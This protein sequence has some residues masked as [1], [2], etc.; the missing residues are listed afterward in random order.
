M[1]Y[2]DKKK[3]I[4]TMNIDYS[5]RK[6]IMSRST[7]LGYCICDPRKPCPCEELKNFNVCECAGEKM[8]QIELGKTRIRLTEHVKSAGCASKISKKTLHEILSG[9]PQ[10][11]DAR[12]LVGSSAGDDAGVVTLPGKTGKAMVLTVDVFAPSVD[13]PYTFG[14]ISAANSVSDIYAMGAKPWCAL[15]IIGFPVGR[16]PDETMKQIL[17]GGID[18]MSEVGIA[19]VGGHSI[20]DDNIKCGF[21]V[22]GICPEKKFTRNEGAR[23]GDALILTKPLGVGITAFAG[24]IGHASKKDLDEIAKSMCVLNK[25]ASE[26]MQKYDVHAATD[27]TGFSLIGHLS[28][29]V[30]NSSVE[31]DIDFDSIPLF[32]GVANFARRGIIPGAVERNRESVKPELLD[33][34]GLSEPQENIIFCPETSGGLLI[35]MPQRDA[36]SYLREIRRRGVSSAALIGMTTKK[37]KGGLIRLRTVSKD[38]FSPLKIERRI[39]EDAKAPSAG[40]EASACCSSPTNAAQAEGVSAPTVDISGAFAEYM[41]AV[42]APGSINAK[43][44]KLMSL[45]LSVATKCGPCI[46]INLQA[47]RAAGATDEEISE[48]AAI[49]AAFGGASAAMFYKETTQ[50]KKRI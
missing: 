48:A 36:V 33:L 18:K 41:K 37:R 24:Q 22:I 1:S 7:M 42:G 31:V 45:S 6:R 30:K 29:I 35:F 44:K 49:G 17:R 2:H 27:V 28:E 43:N 34:S 38:K 3:E 4:F 32:G 50:D 13:D 20:N 5:K 26:T 19:V 10:F 47:S 23:P 11:D 46:T 14:Q 39:F 16:F 12:V 15:S 25:T 21:A 8:P 40:A 9:L